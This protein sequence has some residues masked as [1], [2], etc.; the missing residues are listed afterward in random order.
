MFDR[1]EVIKTF[2]LSRI[3]FR[4]QIL[5][6]PHAWANKFETAIAGFLWKGQ[7]VKNL[8]SLESV[9]QPCSNGGLGIPFV[10]AKCDALLLKQMLRILTSRKNFMTT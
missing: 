3:W 10:R 8:L 4:A 9:C 6:L 2:A 1:A 5:P 7:Q